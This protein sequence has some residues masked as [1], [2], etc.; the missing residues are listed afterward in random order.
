MPSIFTCESTLPSAVTL[1]RRLSA[2][3]PF[4]SVTPSMSLGTLNTTPYWPVEVRY[5]TPKV[6]PSTSRHEVAA[7]PWAF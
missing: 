5:C 7:V 3:L 1:D 2:E 6:R 4:T